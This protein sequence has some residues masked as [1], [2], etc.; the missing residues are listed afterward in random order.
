M[1]LLAWLGSLF[2]EPKPK[3]RPPGWSKTLDAL[4]GETR[5]LS[6]DEIEWARQY[7]REQLRSW[8]R[9]PRDGEQFEAVR[10]LRVTYVIHWRAPYGT[11]G[12]GTLARGTRVR[13]SVPASDAEPVGVQAVPVDEKA[14]GQQLVPEADRLSSKYDGYSLSLT[15]SQLNKD[16]RLV[17]PGAG[18]PGG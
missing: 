2:E 12:E 6:G 16:F 8:A 14:I 18:A 15:V 4:T 3:P 9:F 10:D 13:V 5:S 1:K 7:E 11:G 17:E